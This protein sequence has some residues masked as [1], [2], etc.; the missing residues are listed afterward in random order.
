MYN[1]V[2]FNF[3]N[4]TSLWL[5]CQHSNTGFSSYRFLGL[6]PGQE[7][8]FGWGVKSES[9][10]SN[11]KL[12]IEISYPPSEFTVFAVNHAFA[13]PDVSLEYFRYGV[14]T[15]K[16]VTRRDMWEND[17]FD[18]THAGFRVHIHR[19]SNGKE[20]LDD[21]DEWYTRF[22]VTMSDV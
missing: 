13:V 4:A 22:F 10:K 18:V 17:S 14:G 16:L 5:R 1:D 9:L 15:D 19:W 7:S 11:A 3:R 21:Y 20:P 12:T 2:I 8:G 6:A